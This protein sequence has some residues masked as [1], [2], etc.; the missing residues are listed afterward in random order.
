MV[1][2]YFNR[3]ATL[4][5]SVNYQNYAALGMPRIFLKLNEWKFWLFCFPL[6]LWIWLW[7]Y[8]RICLK[9]DSN[10]LAIIV[11]SKSAHRNTKLC[12]YSQRDGYCIRTR[13]SW[14]SVWR[15]WCFILSDTTN[16]F[17]H[18]LWAIHSCGNITACLSVS[19]IEPLAAPCKK[20]SY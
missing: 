16:A 19:I 11:F 12:T 3:V 13:L 9:K 8:L 1:C 4:N 6:I 5:S 18:G 20:F 14:Y 2:I 15:M 7:I 10:L 17:T